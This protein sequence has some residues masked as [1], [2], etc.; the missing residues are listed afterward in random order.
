MMT[1]EEGN[2]E[3]MKKGDEAIRMEPYN[4]YCVQELGFQSSRF[5]GER[6]REGWFGNLGLHLQQTLFWLRP[7]RSVD[8]RN[9]AF[10]HRINE[11]T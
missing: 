1:I 10:M 11:R 7:R 2:E 3:M 5:E 9:V 4:R 8:G 6:E